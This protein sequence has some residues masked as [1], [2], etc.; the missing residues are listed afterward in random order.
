MVIISSYFFPV[1]VITDR[2]ASCHLMFFPWLI[3][4]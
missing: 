1:V 3:M 4:H 2:V